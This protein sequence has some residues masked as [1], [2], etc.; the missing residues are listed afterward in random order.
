MTTT[1]NTRTNRFAAPCNSCGSTVQPG[2]GILIGRMVG[3]R[4]QWLVRHLNAEACVRPVRRQT[5]SGDVHGPG[6][7][8]CLGARCVQALNDRRRA[9]SVRYEQDHGRVCRR[10]GAPIDAQGCWE[11]NMESDISA[12]EDAEERARMA[13]KSA[14]GL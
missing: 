2:A 5:C 8:E 3:G 9:A 1:T 12:A 10:H 7:D 6:D 14:R 11:C 4:R 13:F